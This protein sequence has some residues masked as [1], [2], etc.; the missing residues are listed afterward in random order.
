MTQDDMTRAKDTQK[1]GQSPDRQ[2]LG[3]LLRALDAQGYDFMAPTPASQAR[4]LARPDRRVGS[5]MMDL[6]G[7]TLHAAPIAYLQISS[8]CWSKLVS[9]T[10]GAMA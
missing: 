3:A 9:S 8:L 10:G 1:A 2:A 4:V 7:W 6:L 5:G